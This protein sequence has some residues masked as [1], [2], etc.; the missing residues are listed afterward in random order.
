[1]LFFRSVRIFV[2]VFL[3]LGLD[4]LCFMGKKSKKKNPHKEPCLFFF[5]V[6]VQNSSTNNL[7][8]I[9]NIAGMGSEI[10]YVVIHS[11]ETKFQ[12]QNLVIGIICKSNRW[13]LRDQQ[14]QF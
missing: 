4:F 6:S 14:V 8:H 1:M 2:G 3:L 5:T 12:L 11:S 7:L 9:I 10:N 13:P